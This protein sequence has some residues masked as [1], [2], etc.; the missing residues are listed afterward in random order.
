MRVGLEMIYVG[1]AFT[2]GWIVELCLQL[3]AGPW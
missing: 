3:A 2:C 1:L